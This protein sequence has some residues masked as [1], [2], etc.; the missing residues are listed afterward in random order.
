MMLVAGQS[1]GL[2]RD[3]KPAGEIVR[4]MMEEAEQVIAE[5]LSPMLH[6]M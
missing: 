3:I 1:A 6:T 4:E 5:R 2:V